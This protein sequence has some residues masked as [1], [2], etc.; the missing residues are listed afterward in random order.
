MGYID[1]P[2][3]SPSE[4]R[5]RQRGALAEYR[6]AVGYLIQMYDTHFD[7]QHVSS[8]ADFEVAIEELRDLQTRLWAP[9]ATE[10]AIDDGPT[11]E[12]GTQLRMNWRRA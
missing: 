7:A 5:E 2:F 11:D 8:A 3:E 12:W 9:T 1:W 10:V 6:A 4:E